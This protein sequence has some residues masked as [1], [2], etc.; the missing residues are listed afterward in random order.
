MV[1][2]AT[3]PFDDVKRVKIGIVLYPDFLA[4]RQVVQAE[5]ERACRD[6][7]NLL[8]CS[9]IHIGHSISKFVCDV[10][11]VVNN[12]SLTDPAMVSNEEG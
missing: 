8:L 9:D 3:F 11:C 1:T 12:A 5:W 7:F 2:R 6:S 10:N 4:S